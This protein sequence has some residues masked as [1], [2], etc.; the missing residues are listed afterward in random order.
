M[1]ILSASVLFALRFFAIVANGPLWLPINVVVVVVVDALGVCATVA[2]DTVTV[3]VVYNGD[4][5]VETNS[6]DVPL[7]LFAP[8][9]LVGVVVAV[10][11][12]CC[13]R[14][15]FAL[16]P[17]LPI[18]LFTHPPIAVEPVIML[19]LLLL[20]QL[21]FV[22]CDSEDCTRNR[23]AGNWDIWDAGAAEAIPWICV[24]LRS[25]T[26]GGDVEFRLRPAESPSFMFGASI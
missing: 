4:R 25:T 22:F 12:T 13:D 15:T 9:L 19:L 24:G 18:L 21:S 23:D 1:I 7:R 20:L 11:W 14:N 17:L 3:V 2:L 10:T 5:V 16:P 26:A 8:L 6:L